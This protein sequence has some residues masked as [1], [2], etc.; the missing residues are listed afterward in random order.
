MDMLA[1]SGK[2]RDNAGVYRN[3]YNPRIKKAIYK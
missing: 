2:K 1:G 3:G